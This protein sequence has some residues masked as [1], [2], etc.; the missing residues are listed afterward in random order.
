MLLLLLTSSLAL[1]SAAGGPDGANC[2]PGAWLPRGS[3]VD[4]CYNPGMD[5]DGSL[6]PDCAAFHGPSSNTSFFHV[7]E[8]GKRVPYQ[9]PSLQI[10]ASSGSAVPRAHA[11]WSALP[12]ILTQHPAQTA[13]YS[14]T[15]G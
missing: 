13:A 7:H 6:V 5:Y 14:S 8:Y 1:T 4:M 9:H 11:S 2:L 15:A 10:V 3:D 12:A